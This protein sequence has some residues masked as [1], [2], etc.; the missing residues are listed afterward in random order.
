[1][2]ALNTIIPIIKFG[3]KEKLFSKINPSSYPTKNQ[4]IRLK[5]N[6]LQTI[7]TGIFFPFVFNLKGNISVL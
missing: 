2:P 4:L 1:M 6:A 5:I 7:T 3:L